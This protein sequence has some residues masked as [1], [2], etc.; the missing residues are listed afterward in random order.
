MAA[1]GKDDDL[2]GEWIALQREISEAEFRLKKAR[3]V[4][5]ALRFALISAPAILALMGVLTL[6]LADLVNLAPFW[7]AAGIYAGVAA[8]VSIILGVWGYDDK[9][10][11][12]P[13]HIALDL[14]GLYREQALVFSGA[15]M[16]VAIRQYAFRGAMLRTVGATR[17]RGDRYRTVHNAFQSVIII[18]SLATTTVASL[19]PDDGALKWIAVG[20]SFSVGIAAGFTGYFKYRER[21]FYLRQ[22]ADDIEEQLNAYELGLPPYDIGTESDRIAILTSRTEAIRVAQQRREQQLDQPKSPDDQT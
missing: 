13:R 2:V 6:V 20:L 21:A 5:S 3:L 22:T 12:R 9:E 14:D 7:A 18:G 16:D 1:N 8:V 19:N 10:L 17:K 11:L 4:T 15:R